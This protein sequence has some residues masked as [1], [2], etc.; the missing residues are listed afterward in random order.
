MFPLRSAQVYFFELAPGSQQPEWLCLQI[1]SL[2]L[3]ILAWTK[4]KN[5]FQLRVKMKTFNQRKDHWPCLKS[6]DKCGKVPRRE[7][8]CARWSVSTLASRS[9]CT[10]QSPSTKSSSSCP[11]WSSA[12]SHLSWHDQAQSCKIKCYIRLRA[13]GKYGHRP[14]LLDG[15]LKTSL[16]LL[17]KLQSQGCHLLIHMIFILPFSPMTNDLISDMRHQR[18]IVF[19]SKISCHLIVDSLLV[20]LASDV[21]CGP[22]NRFPISVME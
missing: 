22:R 16:F 17:E 14:K 8:G 13:S 21:T 12:W 2:F 9:S 7:W 4:S 11:V 18:G 20:L 3:N 6:S 5:V 15:Y 10:V 19:F 1:F